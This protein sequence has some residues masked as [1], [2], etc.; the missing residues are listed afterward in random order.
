MNRQGWNWN[1][2]LSDVFSRSLRPRSSGPLTREGL[3][4]ILE[5]ALQI[6]DADLGEQRDDTP[7]SSGD[8]GTSD[9]E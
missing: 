1:N 3:V 7:S 6:V 4:A 9:Q 2:A 5:E 8:E